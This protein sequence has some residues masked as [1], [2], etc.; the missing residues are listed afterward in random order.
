MPVTSLRARAM[1]TDGEMSLRLLVVIPEDESAVE[2]ELAATHSSALRV[3]GRACTESQAL[4]SYFRCAPDVVVLD[5]RLA[6]EEPARLVGL[7][8]RV[9]PGSCIVALVPAE[10]SVAASAARA[11]GADAIGLLAE[12]PVLLGRLSAAAAV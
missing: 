5:C 8:K 7:L 3:V 9:A 4:Q 6:P 11:L 12:L 10:D 1:G 2:H